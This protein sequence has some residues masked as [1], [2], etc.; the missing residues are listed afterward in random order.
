MTGLTN[1]FIKRA[2]MAIAALAFQ[3][4]MAQ[5]A[6]KSPIRVTGVVMDADKADELPYVNIAIKGTVYGTSTDNNGYFS[7]FMNPGD[8]LRFTAVGYQDA[9]FV[10]PYTVT[11]RN[12]SLVQLMRDETVLLKEVVVFPWP[13]IDDFEQAFMDAKPEKNMQDLIKEVQTELAQTVDSNRESEYYYDQMRYQRLYELNR[14]F[15]PNNFLNPI[16]WSNF[17]KDLNSGKLKQDNED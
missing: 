1:K 10:L 11:G 15:P 14:Q 12:Y 6:V 17:I 5:D 9:A 8:T 3:S 4:G 16:R 2:I 13:D 7:L